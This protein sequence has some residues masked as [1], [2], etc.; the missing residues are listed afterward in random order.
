MLNLEEWTDDTNKILV[1]LLNQEEKE[2]V[3]DWQPRKEIA[4]ATGLKKNDVRYRVE[5]L[6]EADLLLK[7]YTNINN[8]ECAV[9]KLVEESRKTAEAIRECTGILGEVPEEPTR[10]D[11]LHLTY[12][13]AAIKAGNDPPEGGSTVP[14]Y[15]AELEDRIENLEKQDQATELDEPTGDHNELSKRV[16]GLESDLDTLQAD[17]RELFVH[18]HNDIKDDISELKR[19]I[20]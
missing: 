5:N 3:D 11:I 20:K 15:V 2:D 1:F 9:Y 14:E 13:M 8:Q 12:E 16:D 6:F 19:E 10:D 18:V 7:D 4:R 17:L